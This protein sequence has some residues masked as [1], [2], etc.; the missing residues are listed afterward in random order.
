MW[1]IGAAATRGLASACALITAVLMA[2]CSGPGLLLTAAGVATDNSVTWDI[3]KHLHAKITEGDPTPCIRLDSVER[4]LNA[5]CGPFVPGSIKVRDIQETRLQGCLLAVAVRD[6]RLW[7]TVPELIEK[8]AGP[9]YCTDSP[10]LEL[11]QMPACPDFKSAS[12]AT[13]QA[14]RALAE[15]DPRSVR[16]D[17]MRMLSCPSAVATGL[18]TVL[19]TWLARDDLEVGTVAFGPLDALHPAYLGSRFAVELEKRGHTAREGLG[20]YEGVQPRSFELALRDCQWVA[21]TWW[22]A[23][24]PDLANR[25]PPAQAAQLAWSPLARVL[26]PNF[27]AYPAAQA[28]MVKFLMDRGADP[29]RRLP[30]DDG[31]SIV[32]YARRLHSPVLTLLDPLATPP[33]GATVLAV[34]TPTVA[35]GQ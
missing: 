16:R 1:K 23:R 13:R 30:F 27:L 4:A 3:V 24:A 18:D 10:L 15:Q 9:Q 20:A 21:L 14:F 6:Q 19:D 33:V 7:D 2:G 22:L 8:G 11:A 34:T 17:V 25:V 35:T 26:T 32:D 12:A 5:R 29:R 28:D 31:V